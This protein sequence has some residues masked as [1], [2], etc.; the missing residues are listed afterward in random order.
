MAILL[1][2]KILE[3]AEQRIEAGLTPQNRRDYMR[4][5]VAGMQAGLKDGPHG[6]LAQLKQSQ[7]PISDC[8]IGAVHLALMLRLHSRYSMPVQAMVPGA[9][10]LML[11][12]LDFAD[13]TGIVKVGANE[14]DEATKI[15][16]NEL[17][18]SF[19]ISPQML[20]Q[21]AT[22]AHSAAQDPTKMDIMGR[23]VG[24]L[25]DPRASLPAEPVPSEGAQ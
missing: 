7:N 6:I 1:D 10:T 23:R 11:Q 20:N 3:A 12:A 15:F 14:L 8:A 19:K 9:L 22:Q 5:V 13:R 24:V 17:F 18:K 4:V 21:M 16:A 2:N 25:R